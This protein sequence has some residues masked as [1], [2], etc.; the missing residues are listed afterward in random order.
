MALAP[1]R[2]RHARAPP[3]LPSGGNG[4]GGFRRKASWPAAAR[5]QPLTVKPAQ[6]PAPD[7]M[8]KL[9]A[10]AGSATDR[11]GEHGLFGARGQLQPR[12]RRV[13]R[14]GSGKWSGKALGPGSTG[15]LR[16]MSNRVHF[17]SKHVS[18]S[19]K[20]RV[21]RGSGHDART[22][23]LS[24]LD[25][26]TARVGPVVETLDQNKR[27]DCEHRDIFEEQSQLS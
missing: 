12:G 6:A 13:A 5:L 19:G 21:G 11:S 22:S 23:G 3:Q 18:K 4:S 15:N 16:D 25:R 7:N 10:V 20:T 8:T 26:P 2:R 1:A 9:C 27:R 17:G 14:H 24:T